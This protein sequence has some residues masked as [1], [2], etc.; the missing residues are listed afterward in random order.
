MFKKSRFVF[1]SVICVLISVISGFAQDSDSIT[2][3]TYYPSPYGSYNELSVFTRQAIGDFNIDGKTDS[4]DMAVDSFGNILPGSLTVSGSVGIGTREP[5]ATLDV[6]GGIKVGAS[7]LDTDTTCSVKGIM[8][9]NNS[10]NR[11]EYCDG[12]DW[13]PAFQGQGPEVFIVK[14]T[15]ESVT[16]F[17]TFQADDHLQFPIGANEVWQFEIDAFFIV[18]D[19]GYKLSL[20]GPAGANWLVAYIDSLAIVGSPVGGSCD[21]DSYTDEWRVSHGGPSGIAKIRIHGSVSNGANGGI[22]T[23]EWTQYDSNASPLT[24]SRGSYLI[25]RRAQ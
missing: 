15:D 20:D 21:I 22:F 17:T 10:S 9:Y 3:V 25:A 8:R 12:S 23:L 2:I 6:A 1:I 13:Q 14:P 24:L 11:M 19:S 7:G 18:G 16:S 4:N 5:Q